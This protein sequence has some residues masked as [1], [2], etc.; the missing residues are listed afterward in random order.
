MTYNGPEVLTVH[1]F[2]PLFNS[3]TYFTRALSNLSSHYN[4]N[5][6]SLIQEAKYR[7]LGFVCSVLSGIEKC[8][9]QVDRVLSVSV[10]HSDPM[11][12]HCRSKG[13]SLVL[14]QP[15][16]PWCV[17]INILSIHKSS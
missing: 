1:F 9:S 13:I 5:P 4:R 8:G 10:F 15:L 2:V 7:E 16:D 17:C 3:K 12:L 11:H 6:E 14:E